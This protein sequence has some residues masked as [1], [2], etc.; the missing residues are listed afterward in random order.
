MSTS[1]PLVNV[2]RRLD[3]INNRPL[4]FLKLSRAA[5]TTCLLCLTFVICEPKANYKTG[6]IQRLG[7]SASLSKIL[8]RL[9]LLSEF[10]HRTTFVFTLMW[11][12][13][14][15]MQQM[16]TSQIHTDTY[17][18]PLVKFNFT[19]YYKCIKSV[20]GDLHVLQ[21]DIRIIVFFESP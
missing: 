12:A 21:R 11:Y 9:R 20:P 10:A 19:N 7:L 13:H 18:L 2:L 1:R 4:L 15:E 5:R 8:R 16:P 17:G 3:E 14:H 6:S